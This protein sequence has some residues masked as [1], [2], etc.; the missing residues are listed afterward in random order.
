MKLLLTIDVEDWFQVEN[1]KHIISRTD[2][3]A[4]ESRIEINLEKILNLLSKYNVTATFF[5]LGYIAERF[6]LLIKKIHD[7]NHEVASHGYAHSLCYS[8]NYLELYTDIKKSKQIIESI[9]G[10]KIYGYRAPS[11]SITPTV[12]ELLE[13]FD[14]KYDSSFCISTFNKRYSRLYVRDNIKNSDYPFRLNSKII[15]FPISSLSFWNFYLPWS[16]GFT[17]RLFPYAYYRKMINKLINK[18][19]YYI[20]Y[21]HPWEIDSNMPMVKGLNSVYK[22]RHYYNTHTTFNKLEFLLNEFSFSSAKNCLY[23]FN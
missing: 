16:G 21:F 17:F 8:L 23:N 12:I 22:F 14:F 4:L 11:F 6:P 3:H 7:S 13:K 5:T 18:N 19:N 10:T 1:L 9:I 15:E 20:F 2:W